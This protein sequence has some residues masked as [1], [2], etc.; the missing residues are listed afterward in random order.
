MRAGM[1]GR[2][3]EMQ[4]AYQAPVFDKCEGA[5][6]YAAPIFDMCKRTP[7]YAVRGRRDCERR[8]STPIK[9][10]LE[11]GIWYLVFFKISLG[12]STLVVDSCLREIAV[13]S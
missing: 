8:G 2:G 12:W 6:G 3:A 4:C 5:P 1:M 7:G 11:F 9:I 10:Y 13:G